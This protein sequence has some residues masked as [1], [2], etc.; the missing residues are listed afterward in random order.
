MKKTV[1]VVSVAFAFTLPTASVQG[2]TGTSQFFT[3]GVVTDWGGAN[4]YVGNTGPN[5]YL[6]ISNGS[7]L[8]NAATCYI[9][10]NSNANQN[11]LL[12]SDAG[13]V[14]N[15]TPFATGLYIGNSGSDNQ[16]VVSNGAVA[17]IGPGYMGRQ[18]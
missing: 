3:N 12:V 5:N 18:V 7:G 2:E 1:I 10:N 13:S 6:Q 8:T 15:G 11:T 14:F 9:G 4:L 17:T 16:L